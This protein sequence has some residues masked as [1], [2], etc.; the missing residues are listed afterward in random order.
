MI[1]KW[2][3]RLSGAL[4][5]GFAL[6]AMLNQLKVD[7]TDMLSAVLWSGCRAQFFHRLFSL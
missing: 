5:L 6:L 2:S 4:I 7:E 3:S 1:A